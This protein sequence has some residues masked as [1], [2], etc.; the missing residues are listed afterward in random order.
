LPG[1]SDDWRD[2]VFVSQVAH[3]AFVSVNEQGTAAAMAR[4]IGGPF[5]PTF[6]ADRP[7]V[8]LLRDGKTGTVLFVGRLAAAGRLNFG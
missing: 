4:S 5:T 3:K 1:Q 8:F 7:F 2:K 6:K